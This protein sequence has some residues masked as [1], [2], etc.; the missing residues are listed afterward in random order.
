MRLSEPERDQIQRLYEA[1]LAAC[2]HLTLADHITMAL[3][4]HR[5]STGR[6]QRSQATATGQSKS[7]VARLEARPGDCRLSEVVEALAETRFHLRLCHDG[8]GQPVEPQEWIPDEVLP[9]T[10]DGR[11]LP[12]AAEVYRIAMPRSW[13]ITRFGHFVEAPDWSWRIPLPDYQADE[14]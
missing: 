14:D 6:S 12:A 2:E 7:Q 9:R 5:R 8:S 3:R 10:S 4:R 1:W 11:R 13:F